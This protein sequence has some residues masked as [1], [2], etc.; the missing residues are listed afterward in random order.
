MGN[1]GSLSSEKKTGF[2]VG[3]TYFFDPPVEA[4]CVSVN[5]RKGDN[6]KQGTF[7]AGW[8]IKF[9]K[10]VGTFTGFPVGSKTNHFFELR[11]GGGVAIE[12]CDG[13]QLPFFRRP[14]E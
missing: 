5:A 4:K 3:G 12:D 14:K 2:I 7:S 11:H 1:T 9:V 6:W 10:G 13:C 8:C